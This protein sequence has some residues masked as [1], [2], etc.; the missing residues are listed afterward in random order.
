MTK[1]EYPVDN[2]ENSKFILDIYIY[3]F[4]SKS[5]AIAAVAALVE[6][7]HGYSFKTF[8]DSYHFDKVT[9]SLRKFSNF[10]LV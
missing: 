4:I 9:G 7:A 1:K 5:T 10:S 6:G 3:I 2:C 8:L